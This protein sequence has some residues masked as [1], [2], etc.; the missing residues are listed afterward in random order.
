MAETK[1]S[2][3]IRWFV[4][5]QLPNN[6]EEWFK[7]SKYLVGDNSRTDHYLIFPGM[8]KVGIKLRESNLEFKPIIKSGVP[9]KL[10]DNIFGKTEIWEKWS[11]KESEAGKFLHN[12]HTNNGNNWIT[13]HKRRLLRKY[14]GEGG[15]ACETEVSNF[16][17]EG[18][19]IEITDLEVT[20]PNTN[21]KDLIKYYYWTFGLEAFGR[22]ENL[23]LI[24]EKTL[25]DFFANN[26][27][28]QWNNL[29]LTKMNSKSYPEFLSELAAN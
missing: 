4:E 25:N 19:G 13:L 3:E 16:P 22:N 23:V 2:S 9:L 8:E 20:V 5:N 11:I 21:S 17:E 14:S 28:E 1:Q 18:C 7:T 10:P 24:L 27:S 12:F 29:S 6:V 15:N 26:Q